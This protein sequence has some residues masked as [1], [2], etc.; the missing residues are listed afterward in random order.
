[1]EAG[2]PQDV[3]RE[4]MRG[5]FLTLDR[6]VAVQNT[7]PHF[8]SIDGARCIAPGDAE[9]DEELGNTVMERLAQQRAAANVG[10]SPGIEGPD[11]P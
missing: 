7:I 6:A 4:A 2:F 11:A 9:M 8:G 10:I 1:M 3:V 5:T